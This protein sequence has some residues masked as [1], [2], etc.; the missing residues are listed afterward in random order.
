M[1]NRSWIEMQNADIRNRAYFFLLSPSHSS[2]MLCDAQKHEYLHLVA[3]SLLP[4]RIIIAGCKKCCC[5]IKPKKLIS[6]R[7]GKQYE[8]TLKPKVTVV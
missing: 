4:L 6:I 3:G 1:Y 5:F 2:V 7:Y 8:I